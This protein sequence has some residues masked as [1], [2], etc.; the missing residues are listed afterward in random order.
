MTGF[1][2]SNC[3]ITAH[4]TL[5]FREEFGDDVRVANVHEGP[6]QIGVDWAAGEAAGEANIGD[7]HELL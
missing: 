1:N 2:E 5:A 7:A 4:F 6:V 3:P